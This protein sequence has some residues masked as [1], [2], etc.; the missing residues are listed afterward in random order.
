MPFFDV[1]D[2]SC[3]VMEYLEYPT[4]KDYIKNI[5]E[6]GK[7]KIPN[8]EQKKILTDLAMKIG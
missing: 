1:V 4:A 6:D 7:T 3:I 8:A 5:L 2:Q